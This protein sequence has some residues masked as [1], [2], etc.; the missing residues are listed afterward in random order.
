MPKSKP[1]LSVVIL[2]Y[3]TK[4]LLDN[5]LKSVLKHKNEASMEVIVSDNGSSDG[6]V[7]LVKDKYP[8][9]HIIENKKNLGFAVGNNKAKKYCNG[10]YI[11]FLNSDTELNRGALKETLSYM[12]KHKKMG[13]MT[14]RIVLSNGELDKDARRSFPTPWVSFTHFSGLDRLL[15]KSKTFSKYWYGYISEDKTHEVDVIQGAFFLARKRVIDSVGWFDEDYFL[16]GEDIDLCWKIKEAG[17]KI[18][19]YPKV[20]IKHV[21]KA[22]K[23]KPTEIDRERFVLAGVESMR[24]FYKKHLWEKYPVFLNKMVMI[25]IDTTESIRKF[26]LVIQ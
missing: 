11:L 26:K 6:S 23:K 9:V 25:G 1:T 12:E 17:W 15:P 24:I 22:S 8:V 4:K 13:A 18:V 7:Q 16:D 2:S 5:C 19:Y 10:E 21:K 3:N 20:S 14:C